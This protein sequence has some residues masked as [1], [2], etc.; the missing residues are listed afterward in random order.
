MEYY[1]IY[2]LAAL[3]TAG[4]AWRSGRVCVQKVAIM[5]GMSWAVSNVLFTFLDPPSLIAANTVADV[6]MLTAFYFVMRQHAFRRIVYMSIYTVM[7]AFHAGVMLA[8]PDSFYSYY[9]AQNVLFAA[10]LAYTGGTGIVGILE[11]R[12]PDRI[13]FRR[14]AFAKGRK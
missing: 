6:I 10:A 14:L 11:R 2:G 5:L 4:I 1:M 8:N 13:D 3:V 7:I 9:V 12:S